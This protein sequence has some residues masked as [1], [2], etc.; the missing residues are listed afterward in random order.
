VDI[1]LTTSK[2]V[3]HPKGGHPSQVNIFAKSIL[4]CIS[5]MQDIQDSHTLSTT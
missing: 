1:N 2:S 5:K 4:Q 3:V